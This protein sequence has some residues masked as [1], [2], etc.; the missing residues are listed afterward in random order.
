MVG[1][2][3][4]ATPLSVRATCQYGVAQKKYK[5]NTPD[6]IETQIVWQAKNGTS[7]TSYHVSGWAD[8]SETSG[9]TYQELH[10]IGTKGHVKSDQRDRGFETVLAG[11]G[12]KITN[13]YFYNLNTAFVGSGAFDSKYGFKSVCTFVEAALDVENGKTPKTFDLNLP[14][15]KDSLCVTA[16]LEAADKSLASGSKVIDIHSLK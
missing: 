2:I 16:I 12:Q 10:L 5:I 6:L 8:P 4:G 1:Y 7:F 15:I 13:P 3:T 9:M 11:E 14:T